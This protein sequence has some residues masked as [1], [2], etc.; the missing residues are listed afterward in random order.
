MMSG[1]IV[2]PRTREEIRKDVYNIRKALGY[3]DTPFFPIVQFI[4]LILPQIDPKFHLEICG[5]EQLPG[6][7]AEYCPSEH[8][9]R[10]LES[11]YDGA[12]AD[13]YWHRMTLAHELGHYF[14]HSSETFCLAREFSDVKFP[15]EYNSE[16][17][18]DVFAAELL[19]PIECVQYMSGYR[20]IARKCGVSFQAAKRQFNEV[21]RIKSKKKKPNR[22]KR[23]SFS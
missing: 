15:K 11:V 9:M 12:C 14:Y 2:L 17:Q 6:R 10:I 22:N 4:E 8:E 20:E 1:Y 19:M 23:S 13:Q 21:Q 5:S 16:F 7:L 3:R 18:A